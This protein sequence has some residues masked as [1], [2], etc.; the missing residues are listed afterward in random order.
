MP[1]QLGS[2]TSKN[3]F[4]S[5]PGDIKPFSRPVQIKQGVSYA[6]GQALGIVAATSLAQ[7]FD[8]TASDGSQFCVGILAE[9]VDTTTAGLNAT[10]PA[11]A[12]IGQCLLRTDQ[13]V[14]VTAAALRHLGGINLADNVTQ[15]ACGRQADRAYTAVADGAYTVLVTDDDV[16][17]ATSAGPRTITLPAA[18]TYGIGRTLRIST[19]NANTNNYTIARTGSDTINGATSFTMNAANQTLELRAIVGGWRVMSSN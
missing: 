17:M 12:Y 19:L 8:E 4:H 15:L 7:A 18:A 5:D 11:L 16:A 2:W 9:Y 13:L 3:I 10:C 1:K 14:G 6:P